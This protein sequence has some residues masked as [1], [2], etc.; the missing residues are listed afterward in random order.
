MMNN[1]VSSSM[2]PHAV[3]LPLQLTRWRLLTEAQHNLS[4][5]A[6]H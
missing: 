5:V 6:Q 2:L 1:D 4:G 3:T